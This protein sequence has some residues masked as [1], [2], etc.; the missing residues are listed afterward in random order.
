MSPLS[1]TATD[2]EEMKHLYRINLINSITG[3]KS[4]NLIGTKSKNGVSNVAVFSS[5]THFGSNPA[6]IGVVMRP[7][8][9]ARNTYGNII[10][11]KYY[12]INHINQA[13]IEDAHHTSAKYPEDISEFDKTDLEEEY[14]ND[15]FAPFVKQSVIKIAMEL[16]ETIPIKANGT[17]LVLGRVL[18]LV[19]PPE[20]IADDG[21]V[22]LNAAQTVAISGL[23]AYHRPQQQARLSYARPD[24]KVTKI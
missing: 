12:T 4:A 5:V 13:I 3:Y 15:F 1:I 8:T 20:I 19:L 11:T 10:N 23:D 9:V 24:Q 2:I 6:L 16:V 18:E 17:L 14:I 22:D 21:F 7:T